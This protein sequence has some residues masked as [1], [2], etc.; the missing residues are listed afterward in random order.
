M[1]NTIIYPKVEILSG[2]CEELDDPVINFSFKCDDFQRHAF[3]SIEKGNDVFVSVPTSGGKTI[4]AEY[5]IIHTIKKLG[6]R[7]VYTSPI[8]SL[9][10]EK[11]NEFKSKFNDISIGLLTGDNKIDVD[12]M[13][14]IVTAEILR[15]SLYQLKQ[16]MEDTAGEINN[17]FV[18]SIG[19][20][21]MDEI[22]FMNDKERGKVWEET[23]VLL[24]SSVQLIMLSATVSNPEKFAT[25][26]SKCHQKT[27]SLIQVTKRI[28]PLKHYLFV[29]DELYLFLDEN[30]N[31]SSD[32]F[33]IA[34]KYHENILKKREKNHKSHVDPN[35]I[36]NLINFMKKKDMMQTIFFSFS[37]A[38]C[39]KYAHSVE[40]DLIDHYEQMEISGIF[41]HYMR[42]YYKKYE[43][44]SQVII[45]KDL[46]T[47]GIA[48][49]HSGLLPILKEIIEIIFKKGLIKVLFATETFAVGVNTPTRTVVFTE[50]MKHTKEGKRFITTSEYKQ[51]SG[52]A[53]R[54]GLDEVGHVIILPTFEL[55][56]EKHLRNIVLGCVPCIDSKFTW[57]YQFFL[58]IIL[59]NSTSIE[60]FFNKSLIN[61]EQSAKLKLLMNDKQQLSEEIEN[62]NKMI[63]DIE[64]NGNIEP[65]NIIIKYDDQQNQSLLLGGITISLNKK[66][67]QEYKKAKLIV[68]GNK[69]LKSL[70]E[71][72]KRKNELNKKY[73]II[74]NEIQS[75]TYYVDDSSKNIQTIL[76]NWGYISNDITIKG[77]MAAQVNECNS[78]ILTEIIS[79]DY[80]VDLTPEE[81]VALISIFTEPIKTSISNDYNSSFEGTPSLKTKIYEI[82]NMI[83]NFQSM[84][85][86]I[87]G[88]G[89]EFTDWNISTDYIDISYQWASGILV[90]DMLY[91]LIEYKEYEGNFVRNMLKIYN[92][93]HDIQCICKMI[94]KIELLP[95]LE[96]IDSLILRDIVSINSLYLS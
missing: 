15:N 7:V 58:K 54:R 52:R 38:N 44:V 31:Y 20:V 29:N 1:D 87:F 48:F 83:Q 76:Y 53:G 96:K 84:E 82:N 61:L 79:R 95:I 62:I 59:S 75:Y 67:I 65:I 46:L 12:S 3:K 37:R 63:T 68:N 25:W 90:L 77:V 14:L 74:T 4:V 78:I 81:I 73:D 23:I 27:V 55:P 45:V 43:N 34:R 42:P 10:N 18:N 88:A 91:I 36:T 94:G 6:K 66:Q 8:K 40:I 69:T 30:N 70:Y 85:D 19:C 86:D 33:N 50:L 64:C 9:S 22:H 26:V 5:A 57:D 24:N 72:I 93:I 21:I 92:I 51:M 60:Q 13:C 49:H 89:N 35:S 71:F 16:K 17:D 32:Q 28:I 41:D 2:L 39:E 80:L 11:Y 47:K 56:E